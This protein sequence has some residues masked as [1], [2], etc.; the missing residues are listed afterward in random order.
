MGYKFRA[1]DLVITS[2]YHD[3]PGHQGILMERYERHGSWTWRIRWLTDIP[4]PYRHY[5]KRF[6]GQER[7]GCEG[8]EMET[9]LFNLRRRYHY[10]NKE[11]E[12]Y[13]SKH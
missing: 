11:G 13:E 2:K 6:R 5:Q 12:Y 1:G 8:T 4:Y 7:A 3:H 9:N 10:Y